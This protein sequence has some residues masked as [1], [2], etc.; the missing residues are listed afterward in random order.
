MRLNHLEIT[1]F[2]NYQQLEADL[3]GEQQLILVGNNGQGKTNFL[4]AIVVLAL[5]KP[6][7]SLP[8]R[9]LVNWSAESQ[10]GAFPSFLR[11][12]GDV[13]GLQGQQSLEVICGSTAKM[14][15]TLKI[16]GQKT[17]AQDYIGTL[18]IVLFTP[19]D[20]NMMM[21]APQLRRRYV[22]ILI[23]QIDREYLTHLSRYQ[24]VLKHRN[25]LLQGIKAREAKTMELD[26]WDDLLVQ[27][28]TVILA[29]RRELFSNLNVQLS[30]H[31]QELSGESVNFRLHWKKEWPEGEEKLSASF[32][33]YISDRR[34][35]DIEAG[36][37]C[38]GPH[39]EDFE[40]HMNDRNLS[41][42]GSRG[43]CRTAILAL[44]LAELSYMTT[45][46]GESPVLLL[47][48]VFSELDPSRQKNLLRLFQV[49]QVI[50]T[51]THLD[52]IPDNARVWRI[53]QGRI[54]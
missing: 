4:E 21:L 3:S 40:F 11:V 31:Y 10:D 12:K 23:S 20:M 16:D 39:R 1:D 28:G 15:K 54:T 43:E 34:D 26:Y 44:K 42:C 48:D 29:K 50:M 52:S 8:L 27:H 35:R 19:Q 32:R 45:S 5:S 9:E 13:V 53:E 47:D 46:S 25:R 51:S 30:Q 6:L 7:Q 49:D 18:K 37:T 22:N 14:P 38:G 17:K 33:H 2:K 41:Q 36:N 24:L